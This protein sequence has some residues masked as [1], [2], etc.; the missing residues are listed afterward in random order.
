MRAYECNQLSSEIKPSASCVQSKTKKEY[1][2]Q[3]FS[4]TNGRYLNG[5]KKI[6]AISYLSEAELKRLAALLA[7]FPLIRERRKF[8]S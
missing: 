7:S 4:Q 3:A 1:S 2:S 6:W 5:V 8:T